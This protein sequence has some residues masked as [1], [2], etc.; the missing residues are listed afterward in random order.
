MK[1]NLMY[2]IC[3]IAQLKWTPGGQWKTCWQIKYTFWSLLYQNEI[4]P[5][6]GALQKKK[7][8]GELQLLCTILFLLLLEFAR[9]LLQSLLQSLWSLPWAQCQPTGT[10]WLPAFPV[11]NTLHCL[12]WPSALRAG[13]GYGECLLVRLVSFPPSS[14][15]PVGA[16]ESL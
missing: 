7:G 13:T 10:S 12:L 3:Y 15:M 16:I 5:P 6:R 14:L 1:I 4:K 9:A 8:L 2:S 11:P